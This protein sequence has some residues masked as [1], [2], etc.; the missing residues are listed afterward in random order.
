MGNYRGVTDMDNLLADLRRAARVL[1]ASPGLVL[2]SVLSLGLGLGANL[3][4]FS[5]LRAAFFYQPE[6]AAPERVV[7]V[8]PGNSNQY[9]YLNFRDLQESGVFESVAG[10]RR[11]QLNLRA[12][13]E[14][15]RVP[16]LAVTAD[17]FAALGIPAAIGR[18]FD[19]AEAAPERQPRVAVL[20]HAFW[21]QRFGGS[22]ATIRQSVTMN[23][24]AFDIIGVLHEGH[25]AITPRADPSIYVPISALVLPTIDDR[26]NGNALDVLGRL[27]P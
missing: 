11:V 2:V 17:F 23:G 1:G 21:Q 5:F 8:Q 13:G 14:L 26:S 10:F 7:G 20:S 22:A 3:T 12:G 18:T 4:L 9:S 19:A 15:E 16:G 25:R 27:R 6:V 24:E